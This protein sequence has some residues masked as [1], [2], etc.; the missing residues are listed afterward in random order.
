M[1]LHR[2]FA[3]RFLTMFLSVFTLFIVIMAFIDLVEHIRKFANT[4]IA[5]TDILIFTALNTPQTVYGI[6]PL[7]AILSSIGLFLSIARSSEL[8][9]TRAAGRSALR[10]LLAPVTVAL[11]IGAM[12]VAIMNPIVAGTQRQYEARYDALRGQ[13]RSL[14]FGSSG[15]WLR[16]GNTEQQTVIHAQ[17]TNLNGT[18]LYD[19]TFLSFDPE[20]TPLERISAETAA[21]QDGAWRL[22]DV[23]IWP[24]QSDTLAEANAE[25]APRLNVPSTLTID[26]IRD[27]FG[28]PSSIPIWELPTFIA[29]LKAAGFSAQRYEVWLQMELALPLFL[30]AM[31]MVAAS[32]TMRHQRSGRTGTMVMMA[33]MLSFT[34]YFLRNF[35]Q[36]LG[37]NGQISPVLA[38]WAPPLIAI[39]IAFG[40]LLHQEDG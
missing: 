27:S 18:V 14:S 24:L 2:Y 7:I 26:Q 1:I 20:G 17:S 12:C 16:Q 35:T 29:R 23:K 38:A 10:A 40:F 19:A 25:I 31:V 9:V 33:I 32:F 4:Q 6:L 28:T 30:V 39:G 8:V 13:S 11:V 15:L 5:F 22:E 34:I 37:E 36:I 21:L 3:R